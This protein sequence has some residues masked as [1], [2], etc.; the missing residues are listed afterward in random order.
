MAGKK[1]VLLNFILNDKA[2]RQG[3]KNIGGR[4][5]PPNPGSRNCRVAH[6]R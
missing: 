1:D 3:L 2:A 6:K 5:R 4:R